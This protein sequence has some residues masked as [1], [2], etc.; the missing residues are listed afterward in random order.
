MLCDAF[1]VPLR[2][3]LKLDQA[4]NVRLSPY[5]YLKSAINSSRISSLGLCGQKNIIESNKD[6]E[7]IQEILKDFNFMYDKQSM[8]FTTCINNHDIK[9]SLVFSGVGSELRIKDHLVHAVNTTGCKEDRTAE[10]ENLSSILVSKTQCIFL[11]VHV[12]LI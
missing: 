10:G 6:I 7:G 9:L 11:T 5:T 8:I 2:L 3:V 1:D 4:V 12:L